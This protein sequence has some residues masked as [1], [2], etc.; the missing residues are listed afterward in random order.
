LKIP[1]LILV[2]GKDEVVGTELAYSYFSRY[3][4]LGAPWLFATQ[5]DTGHFCNEDATGLILA[6]LDTILDDPGSK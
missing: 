6:W 4:R 1:E 2:G 3:W 5:N